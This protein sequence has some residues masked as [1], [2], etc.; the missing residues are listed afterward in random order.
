[1]AFANAPT[2]GGRPGSPRPVGD[3]P[4]STKNTYSPTSSTTVL[5]LLFLSFHVASSEEGADNKKFFYLDDPNA[6]PIKELGPTYEGDTDRPDLIY[7]DQR[8]RLI[9]CE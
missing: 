5:L 1:M 6:G 2:A 4:F 3:I 8:I 7:D 9:E